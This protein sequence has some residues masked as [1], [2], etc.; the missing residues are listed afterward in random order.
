ML[1][2]NFLFS[3]SSLQ[4]YQ[5]CP[6]RFYLRYLQQLAYPAEETEPALESERHLQQ[7]EYF[8]RLVHQSLLGLPEEK[9]A[10]LANT[11]DLEQWWQ[12]WVSFRQVAGFE[13]ATLYPEW[14]LSAPLGLYR[15]V[16][17]YDLIVQH[18][19]GKWVI[20]DWKTYRR[21]PLNE[22]LAARWQTRLYPALLCLA[23][24]HL[25]DGHPI[26]P[27]Q[28]EMI[29]WFADFPQD[30]ATFVYRT[31]QFQ[32]DQDALQKLIREILTTSAFPPT[33]ETRRCRFCVYRGYCERGAQPGDFDEAEAE[34]EAEEWF[35]I[36]FDQIGEIAF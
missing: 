21:R 30:P 9:L 20:Y 12:N 34:M 2:K 33:E 24:A 14:T 17:K 11:R 26:Q 16:A 13:Q 31:A 23:G 4:D 7:G 19:N 28:V 3:Q 25:N 1:P 32:R 22:W 15:V 10:R 36:N 8:H 5:D 18:P 27:E 6:K 35:N 29:Y